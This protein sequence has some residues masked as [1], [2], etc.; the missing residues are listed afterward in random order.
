[1]KKGS[2]TALISG[3]SGQDGSYLAEF[4]LKKGYI[5]HGL[6]RRASTFN[7]ERIKHLLNYPHKDEKLFLHYGDLSD[8]GSI[9]AI[10]AKINPDE[11]YNLGAQSHVRVSFDVPEYTADIT[12]LGTLRMLEAMRRYAPKARFYQASSSEMF[13]K[14]KETPQNELTP[15]NAQSPYGIAKVFAHD[16]ACRYRDAYGLFISCGI[17]FNHECLTAQTPVIIKIND[18][19]DIVSIEEIIPH[20]ENSRHG[21]KYSTINKN[22]LE[23]WDAD[24]WTK[25]KILTATWNKANSSN[26]KK[27]KKIISRGGYYEAT[28]DHISF[29]NSEKEIKTGEISAG[30]MLELKSF[31]DLNK[32]TIIS[33]EEAEFLGMMVADGYVSSDGKGRFINNDKNLREKIK[34]LWQK[35][36]A[37]YSR[38]DKHPSG[39]NIEKNVYSIEFSGNP[40]Y[41]RFIHKEIYNQKL[42]KKVPRRIL[43]TDELIITSFLKGYNSC[44]GL[45]GGRQ[46]TE[47]KSFTTN[48]SVLALGLWYLVDRALGLRI[49]L[50]P[51]FRKDYLYFHLN[52]NSNNKTRKGKHLRREISEVKA[53]KEYNY[54]GWLFDL[55]TESGTFSAG[56]GLTWVHNSPRRGENFVTKKIVQGVAQIKA[57]LQDKLY[58]GNLSAKR[59]WG[60]SP[61]YCEAMWLMLQQPKPDDFVIAT[62]E[63]HTVKEF[64]ELAFKRAGIKNYKKYIEI[65][66]R[67]YRPNEVNIL[68]G[69]ITKARKILKWRPKTKFADLVNIMTD[70]ELKNLGI[71]K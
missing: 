40:D 10:F 37:G 68:L 47:F 11:I 30:D 48:S 66:E 32:K 3:I 65:D 45:K 15:F 41:L 27:V 9:N 33:L 21:I 2:K 6:V 49:T 16:T 57:G 67:Y 42:F 22:N 20:R 50:H 53:V 64:V 7:I 36:A 8:S 5:V 61:E 25:V 55:E 19:I 71:K 52:I 34:K 38:E 23:I 56:V 14:V 58:L 13:G 54:T 70:F 26:D 1:M 60:Y 12:G 39:F 69:D 51:E 46:K 59:D 4:L 43:N 18:F 24:K 31:P 35:I 63:T 17:L 29:L 28:E 62:G 44:D